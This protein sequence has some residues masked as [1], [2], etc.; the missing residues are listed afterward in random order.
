MGR[1]PKAVRVSERAWYALEAG[2]YIRVEMRPGARRGDVLVAFRRGV[3]DER[4][5]VKV[6][7]APGLQTA[8]VRRGE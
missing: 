1:G 8:V 7:G 6:V 3:A 5:R 4:I 2:E